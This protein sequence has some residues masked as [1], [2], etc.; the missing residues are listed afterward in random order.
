MSRHYFADLN[1]PQMCWRENLVRAEKAFARVAKTCCMPL[2]TS[3]AAC[4]LTS[5]DADRRKKS[6]SVWILGDFRLHWN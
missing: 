6:P 4:A 5:M 3:A 1:M 2:H